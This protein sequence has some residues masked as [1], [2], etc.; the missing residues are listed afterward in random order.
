MLLF[1]EL[2]LSSTVQC[3]VLP[4]WERAGSKVFR[5]FPR[6]PDGVAQITRSERTKHV[7]SCVA[8]VYYSW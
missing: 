3:V 6:E 4:A 7:L 2:V 8:L 1:S 5:V